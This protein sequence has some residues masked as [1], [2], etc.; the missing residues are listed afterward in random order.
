MKIILALVAML[1]LAGCMS[2]S[3]F[4]RAQLN[5]YQSEC[6]G[7]GDVTCERFKYTDPRYNEAM[8]Q[9]GG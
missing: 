2:T 7:K 1:A 6:A 8:R 4:T 3:R 5:M 9:A